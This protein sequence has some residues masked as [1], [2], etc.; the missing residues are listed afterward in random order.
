MSIFDKTHDVIV[1]GGGISG[2][3][4]AIAAARQGCSTLLIERYS[5]LGGM[6]TLGL[7]QPITTW[8]IKGQ[9]NVGGTG[10]RILESLIE[11]SPRAATPMSHYG[12]TC[13]A[14]HLKYVLETEALEH[15]VTLLYHTWVTGVERNDETIARLRVFSKGGEAHI[16]GRIV[17]DATGDADVAAAAGVP[18]ET[19]SQ[20]ITLMMVVAGIDRARCPEREEMAAIYDAHRVGYR[21]LCIF[22]H[23]RE[24]A[25]Y[26]NMTE[27]EGLNGLDVED[28]TAATI[29]CRRQAWQILDVFRAHVPGFEHAYVEQTAPALGVRETRRIRGLYTLTQDDV[30]AGGVFDDV[31]ARASCPIDIHGSDHDG[32][33][34]Y[35]ALKRS[36]GIPYRSLVTQETQN[37]IVAGRPISAD[38][39]AHS[40]LRRMAPGF[41]IGEAAGTA[42]ALAV[43]GGDT[44]AMD[45]ARLQDDLKQFGAV[46]EPEPASG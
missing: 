32:R 44:R 5:A 31:I 38:R 13:D 22:W 10:R 45:I 7:V 34:A 27:V 26:F 21:G 39:A 28:L 6:A 36:Y 37:L 43:D 24:D 41:A 33:G 8:G 3:M 35:E 29:D 1:A 15:G 17:V 30:L 18:C 4:A 46:L 20:G 9:Y 14:E 25:A 11:R 42:A 40:S 23:P 12:P 19:G 2:T 16:E